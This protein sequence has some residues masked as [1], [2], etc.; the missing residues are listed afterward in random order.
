MIGIIE[1]GRRGSLKLRVQVMLNDE[2][3]KRIDDYA[4]K[5]GISRSGLCAMF[6]GQGIMG[7]DK[8]NELINENAEKL[9]N[10]NK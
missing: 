10:E 1:Y 4:K 8:A 3:V 7:F 2:M 9:L 6:I 5:I